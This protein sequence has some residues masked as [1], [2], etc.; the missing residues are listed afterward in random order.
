MTRIKLSL[1]LGITGG[2]IWSLLFTA[3]YSML[4][5]ITISQEQRF[6]F[7]WQ[8]ATVCFILMVVVILAL[9]PLYKAMKTGAKKQ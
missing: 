8:S 6:T 3:Y 1:K 4:P 7:A 2:I 5:Y 9:P